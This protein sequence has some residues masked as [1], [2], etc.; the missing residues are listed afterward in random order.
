MKNCI[1]I[2]ALAI[3]S[4]SSC[5]DLDVTPPDKLSTTIFWKSASD[6][7][8]ALAGLYNT[9]YANPGGENLYGPW[10]DN[11]S[12]N[13]YGRNN[14]SGS[15]DAL[16]AGLTPTS[17]GF[18]NGLYQYSYI[19]IAGCNSFLSNVDKVLTGEKL[20]Q[21]KGE[22][23]FLRGFSYFMLAQTYGNVPIVTEDPFT[24]DYKSKRAKSSRE[25][26]LKQAE[27]DFDAAIASLPDAAFSTGHAVK[28]S[29]Q[30][31]KVR[32][33]LFEQR[34]QEAAALAK[35]IID[36]GKFSLNANYSGNFYKPDQRSSPEILFSVQYQAPVTFHDISLTTLLLNPG[37]SDLQGTQDLLD[38]Y[39][40]GDPRKTMTF[41]SAGDTQADG[42][43]ITTYS[44]QPGVNGWVLGFTPSKKWVDPKIIDPQPGL[45]DDQDMVLLRYADVK[46][47]YAEARNESTGPDASVFQQVNEVR[48]RPGVN[49][50]PIPN[51]LSQMEM[52]ER[53]RHERRVELA[54]EGLRYFDLRR[55]G[56]AE[57]KLNGFIQNPLTP[58]VKMIYRENYRFW[59]IPQTEIDRNAPELI[60]N[61]GY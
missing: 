1:K 43:P 60:Q 28:A 45:L 25:E 37:Y 30:G 58:N 21:Y 36:A 15:Q 41:Y 35:E 16:V 51:G 13:S 10:W 26:V 12:D 53:I 22:A 39:E 59:P 2:V 49:M 32:L 27:N 57:E 50:P 19:T 61:T 9:L 38:E 56:I 52:R 23:L 42:W 8:L 4:L 11:F 20:E 40:P 44:P 54:L 17:G 47:M 24:I 18:V 7:D 29:V 34:F 46:L 6:A 55:W 5:K 14:I 3:I 33:L 48:A 31:Y